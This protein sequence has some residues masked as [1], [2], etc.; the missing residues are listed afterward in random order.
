MAA[1]E[2]VCVI[3]RLIASCLKT[4]KNRPEVHVLIPNLQGCIA[5]DESS[6]STVHR[7][8]RLLELV[9]GLQ[10]RQYSNFTEPYVPQ[11]CVVGG[12]SDGK[13][14]LVNAIASVRIPDGQGPFRFLLEAQGLGTRCPLQVQMLQTHGTT[15]SAEIKGSTLE[16]HSQ[17]Y[18]IDKSISQQS[19]QS[20]TDFGQTVQNEIIQ[21]QKVLLPEDDRIA[22]AGQEQILLKLTGPH[23]PMLTLVDLPGVCI[24]WLTLFEL[25]TA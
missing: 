23:M 2:A 1:K 11:I 15:H 21:A 25:S 17:A 7:Y 5:V 9:N 3:H 22:E 16:H 12:Q 18:K 4:K 19:G 13:S 8:C 24:G 20:L 14:S 10:Q 6:A